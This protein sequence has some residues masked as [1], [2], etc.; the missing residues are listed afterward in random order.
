MEDLITTALSMQMGGNIMDSIKITKNGDYEPGKGYS[1]EYDGVKKINVNVPSGKLQPLSIASS[2]S[3]IYYPDYTE[4]YTGF[5]EVEVNIDVLAQIPQMTKFASWLIPNTSYRL[6]ARMDISNST[7]FR[8]GVSRVYEA[9][10]YDHKPMIVRERTLAT[11]YSC[12]Y[13]GTD[14]VLA[15][16]YRTETLSL[17]EWSQW[18]GSLTTNWTYEY[19]PYTEGEPCF[20]RTGD[21]MWGFKYNCTLDRHNSEAPSSS[22]YSL[23]GM[24]IDPI[25]GTNLNPEGTGYY[26]TLSNENLLNMSFDIY[27]ALH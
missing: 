19:S 15:Y 13:S 22:V 3:K 6:E 20:G 18:D 24:Y 21:N 10:Y 5:S 27:K 9:D 16:V 25:F 4:G 7:I 8:H 17:K 23:T 11:W 2:E 26:T 14:L 12:I 1:D